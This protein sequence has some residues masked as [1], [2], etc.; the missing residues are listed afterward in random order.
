MIKTLHRNDWIRWMK[1]RTY[2][3]TLRN[4]PYEINA[5]L[6]LSVCKAEVLLYRKS[7]FIFDKSKYTWVVDM[8]T[9]AQFNS[10][11]LNGNIFGLSNE[12]VSDFNESER[13]SYK[14]IEEKI[15]KFSHSQTWENYKCLHFSLVFAFYYFSL[16][17]WFPYCQPQNVFYK[18]VG[19]KWEFLELCSPRI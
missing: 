14:A 3:D 7:S 4:F 11:I 16:V 13:K 5:N 6:R 18:W 10:N 17:N 8:K 15:S 19:F 12:F 1:R 9:V 2:I